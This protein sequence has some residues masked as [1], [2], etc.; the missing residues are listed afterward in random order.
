MTALAFP[1]RASSEAATISALELEWLV[2]SVQNNR[3]LPAPEPD[4]VFVGDGDFRAIGAEFLAHLVII[5]GVLPQHRVLDIGSG[6]GRLAVPLTQYLNSEA[7]YLGLDP[8][9]EGIAWSQRAITP[10]YPNFRFRHLD[11][12]HDI[13]NPNGLLRGE[14]L[15]LPVGDNSVDFAFMVSVVTHLP[16]NEVEVYAR[17]VARVLAPGGR[18]MVTSFIMDDVA[19]AATR[20]DRPYPFARTETGP[21]WYVDA[22]APSFGAVAYDDNW[23]KQV[24]VAA[25]LQVETTS[26]GHWRGTPAAH[27]QDILVAT[28]PGKAS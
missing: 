5:G 24:L 14:S 2:R 4:S 15:I 10:A 23:L 18:F 21:D 3:F 7:S 6:L 20:P 1:T 9:R 26:L 19:M 12:A 16:P 11:I 13:Y 22:S 28:K 25:G 27:F 17:E 8:V